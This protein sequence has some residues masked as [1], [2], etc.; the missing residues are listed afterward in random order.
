MEEE[1]D[2]GVGGMGEWCGWQGDEY[3]TKH[4]AAH[5]TIAR[6]CGYVHKHKEL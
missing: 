4:T 5:L 6:D 2:R 3:E 1:W